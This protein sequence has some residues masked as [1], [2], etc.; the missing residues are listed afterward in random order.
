MN[1]FFLSSFASLFLIQILYDLFVEVHVNRF[2]GRFN[3]F[4]EFI[5]PKLVCLLR[6]VAVAP[7]ECFEECYVLL[8]PLV[9]V[10]GAG[11][12]ALLVV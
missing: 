2:I 1:I 11:A 6:I 9:H 5:G 3:S 4:P 10:G 12:R 7:A 8:V